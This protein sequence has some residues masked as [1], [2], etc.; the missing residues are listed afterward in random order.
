MDLSWRYPKNDVPAEDE[1]NENFHVTRARLGHPANR[2]D[3]LL[4]SK[5]KKLINLSAERAYFQDFS[6]HL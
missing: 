2:L 1:Q 6:F 3:C 5:K 4:D